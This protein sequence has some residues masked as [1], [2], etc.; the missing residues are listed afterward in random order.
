MESHLLYPKDF[1][2][3]CPTE[4]IDFARLQKQFDAND[5]VLIGGSTDNEFC[6]LAWRREHPGLNR[7]NHIA[8]QTHLDYSLDL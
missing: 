2:F 8:L 4:I 5:A 6:K 1:T 3:V 7:L